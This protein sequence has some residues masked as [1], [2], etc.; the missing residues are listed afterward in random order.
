MKRMLLPAMYNLRLED[1]LPNDFSDH[2][3]L[4]HRLVG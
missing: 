1:V 4:A 2:R 3:I